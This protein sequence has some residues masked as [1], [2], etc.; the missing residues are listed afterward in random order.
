[1][2]IQK[3]HLAV[4]IFQVFFFCSIL[5]KCIQNFLK[6]FIIKQSNVVQKFIIILSKIEFSHS[7]SN[8]PKNYLIKFYI[9]V[10]L[11]YTLKFTNRDF[12]EQKK[13]NKKI[14]I[15]QNK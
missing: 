9:R 12:K 6:T 14:R 13:H 15:L 2:T 3:I 10:R 7:C 5:K 1:M 8:F 4:C 11:F